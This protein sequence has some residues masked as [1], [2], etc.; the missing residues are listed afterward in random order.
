M[1]AKRLPSHEHHHERRERAAAAR[2][3]RA[4][5]PPA[6]R[7]SRPSRA[8]RPGPGRGR[9]RS[10]RRR[11]A[12][13]RPRRARARAAACAAGSRTS[14]ASLRGL[15]PAAEREEGR[16][17]ARRR[18]PA[19]SGAAPARAREERH[20][21]RRV[22]RAR[23]RSPRRRAPTSSAILATRQALADARRRG[24]RPATLARGDQRRSPPSATAFGASAGQRRLRVGAEARRERGGQARV[25]HE[26]AL[27]AVEERQR[28]PVGLA[29][30]DVA[31][32]RLR[33]ARGQ[34]AEARARRRAPPRP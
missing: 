13:R 11:A 7:T 2:R 8:L 31:A 28:R 25:H 20:E 32:A 19:T 10:R 34:L 14:P 17:P 22:A 21:V 3:R 12:S 27:P 18:A 15:P 33:V 5:G 26:Q 9:R 23:R 30:V 24:A 16:A 6:P 29:Q 1:K 4:P